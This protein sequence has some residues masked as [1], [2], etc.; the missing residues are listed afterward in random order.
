MVIKI[1]IFDNE[2]DMLA[3]KVV[4][5]IVAFSVDNAIEWLGKIERHYQNIIKQALRPHKK[6]SVNDL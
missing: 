4:T 2:D 1:Q 6:N 3:D 5:Q